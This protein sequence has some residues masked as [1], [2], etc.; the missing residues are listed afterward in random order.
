MILRT[1]LAVESEGCR[2]GS[3]KGVEREEYVSGG[4]RVT[5]I[6]IKDDSA[7]SA[8]GK[9]KGRYITADG[10]DMTDTPGDERE[11]IGLAARELQSLLPDKEGTVLVVGLGNRDI[12]PDALGPKSIDHILATRHIKGELKKSSGLSALKSVAAVSPGVLGQTGIEAAEFITGIVNMIKPCAVIAVDAL[13]SR[14]LARLGRTIQLSDTGISPGSGV[15]SRRL[16]LNEKTL[17][18]PVIAFGVPTVVDAA[19][20]AYDILGI[21]DADLASEQI[22][23]VIQGRRMFVTPKETDLLT[24]RAARL[25][26]MAINCALQPDIDLDTLISLVS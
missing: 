6:T 19:T 10:L 11:H 17:G 24:D 3:M 25:A 8:I 13:A 5:R 2:C 7:S 1:D 14:S 16:T 15:G 21:D 9:P 12:T 22:E 23:A 18:V 20:L 4:I 26:G